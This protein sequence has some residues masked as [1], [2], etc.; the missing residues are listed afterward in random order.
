MKL[1]TLRIC[2]PFEANRSQLLVRDANYD[3]LRFVT[4]LP[5]NRWLLKTGI[6]E[7]MG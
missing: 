7:A 6:K 4:S 2:F 5:V 1:G 3:G